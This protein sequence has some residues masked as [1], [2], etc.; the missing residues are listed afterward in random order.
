MCEV[1][2]DIFTRLRNGE[3]IRPDD[4]GYAA[5][6][7]E[8]AAGRALVAEMNAGFR[9]PEEL[10]DFL[11][12]LTGRPVDPSVRIFLPFYTAYGKNLKLGRDIFINF[13]CTFLDLGEIVL[14]DGVYLGPGVCLA[15]ENH[16]EQPELRHGLY[17]RPIRIRKNAWIGAGAVVLP[18]V[19]VGENAIVGAGAV[20]TKDVPDGAV[21][22]G[23]PA[24][25]IRNVRP[26]CR[27]TEGRPL[28]KTEENPLK[29][30][31]I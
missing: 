29:K 12:R 19:T 1:M 7:A 10:T 24:R 3:V 21:V 28:R 5:L 31:E 18:G 6:N 16:P 26:D 8:T 13:D 4:P 17:V 15:T 22:A 30:S 20:V 25:F 11:S 14:E 23:N 27:E 9:T 2:D